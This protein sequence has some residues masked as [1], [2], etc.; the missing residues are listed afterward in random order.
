M[1]PGTLLYCSYLLLIPLLPSFIPSVVLVVLLV[2]VLIFIYILSGS[3]H[4][5]LFYLVVL[6][7][8]TISTTKVIFI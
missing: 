4:K 5:R 6:V 1:I 2:P 3:T 7:P 8:G